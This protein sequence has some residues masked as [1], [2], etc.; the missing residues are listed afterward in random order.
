MA[1]A[2]PFNFLAGKVRALQ[3]KVDKLEQVLCLVIDR[4]VDYQKYMQPQA[5]RGEGDHRHVLP[6]SGGS[7]HWRF[8]MDELEVQEYEKEYFGGDKGDEGHE[9]DAGHADDEG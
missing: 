4:G 5:L 3:T 1:P 8:E 9:G 2:S 7:D 6:E